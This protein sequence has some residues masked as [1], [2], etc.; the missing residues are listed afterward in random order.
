[1]SLPSSPVVPPTPAQALVDACSAL[2]DV[3]VAMLVE[4]RLSG[5]LSTEEEMGEA[6]G[7]LA[8]AVAGASQRAVSGRDFVDLL[9]ETLGHKLAALV[10]ESGHAT[11]FYI[12]AAELRE[13]SLALDSGGTAREDA[14]AA[15]TETAS[16]SGVY[17]FKRVFAAKIGARRSRGPLSPSLDQR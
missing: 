6:Q 17:K 9:K 1:M 4:M 12:S 14:L 2:H 16:A 10:A 15:Y 5:L 8:A 13:A 3:V 11:P 7:E